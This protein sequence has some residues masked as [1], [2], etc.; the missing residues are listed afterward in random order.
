MRKQWIDNALQRTNVGHRPQFGLG[1][2]DSA[3]VLR[4]LTLDAVQVGA[5]DDPNV[6]INPEPSSLLVWSTL[7]GGVFAAGY[8]F[9]HRRSVP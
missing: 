6:L 3:M 9:R 5:V 4:S 8:G 2:L 1:E 7:A